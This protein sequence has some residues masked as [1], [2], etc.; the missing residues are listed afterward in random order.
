MRRVLGVGF[1]WNVGKV[2]IG[3]FGIEVGEAVSPTNLKER[4]IL[5]ICLCCTLQVHIRTTKITLCKKLLGEAYLL[6]CL[7]SYELKNIFLLIIEIVASGYIG[8]NLQLKT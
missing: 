4:T 1:Y 5:K 2:P 6:R 8:S 7:K 3:H